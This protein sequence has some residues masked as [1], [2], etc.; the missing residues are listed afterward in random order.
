MRCGSMR[1]VFGARTRLGR[2]VIEDGLNPLDRMCC[3][4]AVGDDGVDR[5]SKQ[6]GKG[7][8]RAEPVVEDAASTSNNHENT[9]ASFG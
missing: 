1:C 8:E 5:N 7:A 4:N 3:A 9:T 6:K 2:M